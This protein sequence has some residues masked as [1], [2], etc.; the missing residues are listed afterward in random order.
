MQRVNKSS[1]DLW[2]AESDDIVILLVE[3]KGVNVA[4]P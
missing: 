3:A 2:M 1:S 4:V